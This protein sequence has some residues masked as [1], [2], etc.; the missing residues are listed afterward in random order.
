MVLNH[1]LAL[2]RL[3]QGSFLYLKLG[4]CLW[5]PRCLVRHDDF[6]RM[7]ILAVE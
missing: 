5:D 3:W 7:I 6:Q 1:Y 2:T 4:F